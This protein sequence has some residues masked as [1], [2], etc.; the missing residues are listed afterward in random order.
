MQNCVHGL[1]AT[2]STII[3]I[4]LI[5]EFVCFETKVRKFLRQIKITGKQLFQNLNF[6][7]YSKPYIVIQRTRELIIAIKYSQ[8]TVSVT[9]EMHKSTS[10]KNTFKNTQDVII[11]VV[12]FLRKCINFMKT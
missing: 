1:F 8:L 4:I 11:S 7:L 10:D 6:T 2:K 9:R 3:Q 12:T 5:C